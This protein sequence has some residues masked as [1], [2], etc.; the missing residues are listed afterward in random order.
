MCRESSRRR[1]TVLLAGTITVLLSTT[2]AVGQ[3]ETARGLSIP[4]PVQ[5]L[6]RFR[7]QPAPMPAAAEPN[8]AARRLPFQTRTSRMSALFPGSLGKKDLL[9]RPRREMNRRSMGWR[10]I[11]RAR[12]S[13]REC[14]RSTSPRPR[15]GSSGAG[16]LASGQGAVGS[17]L[18]RRHRLFAA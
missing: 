5:D 10:S 18:E 4:Q 2:I 1:A 7:T 14:G 16:A 8:G 3:T 13:S 17:Q 6:S 15:A 12:S 9:P 11:W